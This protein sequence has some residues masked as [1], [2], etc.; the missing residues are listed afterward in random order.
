VHKSSPA[1]HVALGDEDN[2]A[3]L[4]VL[5]AA[6]RAAENHVRA[7]ARNLDPAHDPNDPPVRVV[8]LAATLVAD[9]CAELRSL[10]DCYVDAAND[11]DDPPDDP[12]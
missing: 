12:F 5:A 6:L 7:G 2:H 10:L 4:T 9:R 1:F 3:L 11:L 8:L